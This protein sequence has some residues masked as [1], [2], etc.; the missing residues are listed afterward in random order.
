MPQKINHIFSRFFW[1]R[2]RIEPS[3][4]LIISEFVR[5]RT[6]MLSFSKLKNLFQIRKYIERREIETHTAFL[7]LAQNYYRLKKYTGVFAKLLL[8]VILPHMS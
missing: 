6:C 3:S 1:S 7:A 4:R 8:K 5:P 2:T